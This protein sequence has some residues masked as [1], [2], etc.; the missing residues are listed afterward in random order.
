[1]Q[2]DGY[3]IEREAYELRRSG[4]RKE[5]LADYRRASEAFRMAGDTAGEAHALRHAADVLSEMGSLEEADDVYRETLEL[6]RTHDSKPLDLANAVRAY[7]VLLDK[8][9]DDAG[10][11]WT[12]ALELYERIGIAAGV[13]ECRQRLEHPRGRP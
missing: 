3:A 10:A 13:E 12:R 9:G 2:N 6:Y 11:L 7:A 4:L 5:S 1:M 8:R